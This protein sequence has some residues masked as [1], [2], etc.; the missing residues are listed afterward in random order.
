[1]SCW[2]AGDRTA[3]APAASSMSGSAAAAA[4]AAPEPSAGLGEAAAA[5]PAAR[6]R[7]PGSLQGQERKVGDETGK[8]SFREIASRKA[9]LSRARGNR[10]DPR[11]AAHAEDASGVAPSWAC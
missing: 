9:R 10:P 11:V 2:A 8:G 3:L 7:L 6:C 5:P 1:M 4:S